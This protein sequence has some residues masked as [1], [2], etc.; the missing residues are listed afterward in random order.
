METVVTLA[1][2]KTYE[3][4]L[5]GNRGAIK[6]HTKYCLMCSDQPGVK[7]TKT[8]PMKLYN[9]KNGNKLRNHENTLVTNIRCNAT[10]N[11][12]IDSL[13]AYRGQRVSQ[14]DAQILLSPLDAS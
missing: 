3:G 12:G 14:S 6:L 5:G 13:S 8:I 11:H 4:Q 9:R 1:C 7:Y 10:S 2:G